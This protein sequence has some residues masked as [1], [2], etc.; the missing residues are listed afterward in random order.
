MTSIPA[1]KKERDPTLA[2]GAWERRELRSWLVGELKDR[3]PGSP[4]EQLTETFIRALADDQARH[5]TR[6]HRAILKQEVW[7]LLVTLRRSRRNDDGAI[8][9]WES[10]VSGLTQRMEN[11]GVGRETVQK[12]D[13]RLSET[14]ED[15]RD[16]PLL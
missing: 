6:V 4:H 15:L 16:W 2:F 7:R 1:W 9:E 13:E 12:F 8:A 10:I 14:L 3:I 11:I 5:R